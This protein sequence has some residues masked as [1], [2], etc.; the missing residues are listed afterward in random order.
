MAD[1]VVEVEGVDGGARVVLRQGGYH[2]AMP[3]RCG[4][5]YYESQDRRQYRTP[6]YAMVYLSEGRAELELDGNRYA[7][8][9]GQA[10]QRLPDQ[11]HVVTYEGGTRSHF[12]AVP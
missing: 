3:L 8:E 6:Q 5:Q 4:E 2:A 9:A 10:F 7:V 11:P 12:L 1:K